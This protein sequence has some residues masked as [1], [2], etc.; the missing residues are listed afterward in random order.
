MENIKFILEL[1]DGRQ[2]EIIVYIDLCRLIEEHQDGPD[3]S[4]DKL[5]TFTKLD[6]HRKSPDKTWEVLV[7]WD[8][9]EC[10][11]EPLSLIEKDDPTTCACYDK[12]HDFT[13]STRME[14]FWEDIYERF[15]RL[16]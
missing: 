14:A 8:T 16:P 15:G 4:S 10:K 1:D 12:E 11:G 7:H 6:G 5:W 2:E 3:G 13:G 9:G